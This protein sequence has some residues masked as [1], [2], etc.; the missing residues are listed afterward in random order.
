VRLVEPGGE[1]HRALQHKPLAVRGKA[2]AMQQTF[3]CIAREQQLH[4]LAA[5]LREVEQAM[6]YGRADV[7]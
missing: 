2:E 1:Q 5:R 3:E 7:A 6:A 4:R